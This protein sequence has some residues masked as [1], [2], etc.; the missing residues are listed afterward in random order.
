MRGN[1]FT[2]I[3]VT[4]R[5]TRK[6]ILKHGSGPVFHPVPETHH[7]S[8]SYFHQA[9]NSLPFTLYFFTL[10]VPWATLTDGFPALNVTVPKPVAVERKEVKSPTLESM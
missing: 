1:V 3:Q 5:D 7:R 4:G 6:I 8:L 2:A 10:I 9:F